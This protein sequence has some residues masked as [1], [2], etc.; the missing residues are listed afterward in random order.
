M[1]QL[2]EQGLKKEKRRLATRPSAGSKEKRI[3][4]KKRQGQIKEGRKKVNDFE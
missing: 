3:G 4:H 2:L 1:L